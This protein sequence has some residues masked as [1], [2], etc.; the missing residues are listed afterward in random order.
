MRP[1][2]D[3][4]LTFPFPRVQFLATHVFPELENPRGYLRARACWSIQMF[5]IIKYDH[6][7]ALGTAVQGLLQCLG[8]PE[9]P[10]VMQSATAIKYVAEKRDRDEGSR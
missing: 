4:T 7:E 1:D 5:S 9:L 8:D 6:E 3:L 2:A 10:V